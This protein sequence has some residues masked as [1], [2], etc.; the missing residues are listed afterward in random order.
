M[1]SVS[2]AFENLQ[3]INKIRKTIPDIYIIKLPKRGNKLPKTKIQQ[4][5]QS[6]T[7]IREENKNKI[8]Y[9]LKQQFSHKKNQNTHYKN[10]EDLLLNQNNMLISRV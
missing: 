2:A 6:E 7:E 1:K 4:T 8:K 3:G 5:K 10:N 9:H